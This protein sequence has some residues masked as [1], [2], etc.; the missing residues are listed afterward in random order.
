MKYTTRVI[1]NQPLELVTKEYKSRKNMKHW[2]KG[3]VSVEPLVIE[4]EKTGTT[5][6]LIYRIGKKEIEVTETIILMDLPES[7]HRTFDSKNIY[8]IQENNFEK[9]PNGSTKWTST[10]EFRFSGSLKFMKPFLYAAFKNKSYMQMQ[11]FKV[12][13]EDGKSV[14]MD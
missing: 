8:N 5:V 6:K 9:L 4:E 1:I 14:L 7:I 10:N 2:Q 13:I 3:F 12:F 11:N